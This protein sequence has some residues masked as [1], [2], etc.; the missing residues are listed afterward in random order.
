[1][2][3]VDVKRIGAAAGEEGGRQGHGGGGGGGRGEGEKVL[4][5]LC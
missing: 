2:D 4:L 1:M 5:K 3:L